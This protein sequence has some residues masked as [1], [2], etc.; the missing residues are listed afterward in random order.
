[1]DI[2]D[3]DKLLSRAKMEA[4]KF[5]R[6]YSDEIIGK[7]V[8]SRI[9]TQDEHNQSTIYDISR[10]NKI[11]RRT[12]PAAI[13]ACTLLVSLS[14][15]FFSGILNQKKIASLGEPV[16]QEMIKL[17]ESDSSQLLDYFKI[18]KP[19]QTGDSLLAVIWDSEHDG[20]Y[21]MVY[22]SLFENSDQPGPILMIYFPHNQPDMAVIS[23]ENKDMQ[24]I[25]YRVVGYSKN[26]ITTL[27]EKNYIDGGEIEVQNGVLKE[28]RLV[29]GFSDKIVTHYI[30]YQLNESGDIISSLQNIKINTG[31]YVTFIGNTSDPVE[32]SYSNLFSEWECGLITTNNDNKILYAESSGHEELSIKPVNGSNTE[33]IT[34]EVIEN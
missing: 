34:I 22:S 18:N 1:M 24:Y 7:A 30:P 25:H 5:F 27:M 20:Q 13:I 21:E 14:V 26:Q 6:D 32:V 11:L 23:S 31:E 2:N 33:T 17:N 8:Y 4:D 10:K 12:V 16:S 15:F 29:P 3:M 9:R 19:E 28:T